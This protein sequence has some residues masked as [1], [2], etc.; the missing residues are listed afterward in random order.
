M[1]SVAG[2][3]LSVITAPEPAPA[4]WGDTERVARPKRGSADPRWRDCLLKGLGLVAG[5]MGGIWGGESDLAS[6]G[7]CPLD[8]RDWR[9]LLVEATV[10]DEHFHL[11]FHFCIKGFEESQIL[12]GSIRSWPIWARVLSEVFLLTSRVV[13][14][15][16]AGGSQA[17]PTP[18]RQLKVWRCW[19]T[20]IHATCFSRQDIFWG[21]FQLFLWVKAWQGLHFSKLHQERVEDFSENF[22]PDL[23]KPATSQVV[24]IIP[25]AMWLH[26]KFSFTSSALIP[27]SHQRH[28]DQSMALSLWSLGIC[29][30]RTFPSA[31]PSPKARGGISTSQAVH[32]HKGNDV[33][34]EWSRDAGPWASCQLCPWPPAMLSAAG[35]PFSMSSDGW[36]LSPRLMCFGA[37]SSTFPAPLRALGQA[38]V[39]LFPCISKQLHLIFYFMSFFPSPA[40]LYKAFPLKKTLPSSPLHGHIP[41][42][43]LSECQTPHGSVAEPGLGTT[44]ELLVLGQLLWSIPGHMH[45]PPAGKRTFGILA[46]RKLTVSWKFISNNC[47]TKGAGKTIFF[48]QCCIISLFFFKQKLKHFSY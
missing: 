20:W 36:N 7:W 30:Q 44:V 9:S 15:K 12:F 28:I 35:H 31:L 2:H 34:W 37:N 1:A 26:C 23:F 3:L 40:T 47:C 18:T 45:F 11:H 13:C 29:C 46:E 42:S 33:S 17:W 38:Q 43:I 5:L 24:F 25:T 32:P 6:P 27:K 8:S 21:I 4:L 10:R 48:K 19:M 16:G 14:V 41:S 39:C 22:W